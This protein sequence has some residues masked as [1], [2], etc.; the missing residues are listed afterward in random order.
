[1]TYEYTYKFATGEIISVQS[2]AVK[3]ATNKL[4]AIPSS[5]IPTGYKTINSNQFIPSYELHLYYVGMVANN[6]I[7]ILRKPTTAAASVGG[8][9]GASGASAN[10]R[11]KTFGD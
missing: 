2:I 5:V 4:A 9:S 10:G 1:M 3:G 7:D 8:A 6:D 11:M